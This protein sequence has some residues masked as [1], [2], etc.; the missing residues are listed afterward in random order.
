ML[1]IFKREFK[2]YFQ[3]VIGWLFVAALLAVYGLYFYVYN[4]KN[5]Y[6]YISYNLKGIGF[7]MMIAVPILTMRSLSDERKTK[8]DQLMLTSPVSVGRI[9]AGKYFAMAAVYTI[10]IALFALSPLVLSIYGKVALSEA[11]VALF[12]YWLYG[13]SCIAVGLFISSISESVII[14]AILT[15][16]ALF[17]SYMMQSITGLISSSGNLL[18]KVL[19]CFDLYTPFENF[20]SGCFSVTSA[21][22]YV[23]VILLLCFLTTQSIQKRRWAF[24]K[25]MIGTGAFSAG[26]IVI[27]CAICVVVN[28]V[29]TALPA[30]YTS[31]DCSATKLYSLTSDTKDRVSKLDEDITIYVLNSKKS[32]DA[33]I[34]ET[35]NRYKDL[36][37]HIKVKYVDPATSP[38]FYQDYTDTTPTTNSLIIES[39]NRSKV[40]DY[41]DIY[42]YDSSSYYYGYQSQSSITGYD[43]EGQITSA[44]EYVTMDADELPVIYQI[45]GHNETEIGSN[46]HSVVSKADGKL[47][48]QSQD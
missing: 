1:A 29:V 21:A 33:K 4:L 12:G 41:N 5:G 24:S 45:T 10:D 31:I 39:K 27:M 23:T 43:A 16:A 25:K 6:P 8:T 30:K 3:N 37:S 15:F 9:V 42:E 17:L 38:K 20:V 46:F 2:S 47:I 32:K 44:I 19:N 36:S 13:L 14:S 7:I 48:Y 28:L 35:I 34:D 18:T 11:Y 26:M 40:I 22:Y